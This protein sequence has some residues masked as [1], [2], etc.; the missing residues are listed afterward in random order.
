MYSSA[1][2]IPCVGLE[3]SGDNSAAARL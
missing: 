2:K 1:G 3:S